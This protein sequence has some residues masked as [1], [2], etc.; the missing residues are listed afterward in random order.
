MQPTYHGNE[1]A[2]AVTRQCLLE[3]KAQSGI[4]GV[5]VIEDAMVNIDVPFDL[6]LANFLHDK[7]LAIYFERTGGSVKFH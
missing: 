5:M 3:Q 7:A 1:V 2:Y 4:N 6:E